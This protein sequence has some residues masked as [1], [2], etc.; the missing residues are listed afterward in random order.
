MNIKEKRVI[1]GKNNSFT[2]IIFF[3]IFLTSI[4]SNVE[5]QK[6]YYFSS[7][8]GNDFN[9]SIQ[10]QNPATPLK[11]LNRLSSLF[12]ESILPGDSILFKRGDTF[13]GSLVV[14]KSGADYAPIVISA[15]GTGPK[16]VISGFSTIS[17][18]VSLGSNIY[19]AT[20]PGYKE[21]V[22]CVVINGEVQPIGRYPKAS[23]SNG[24][25]LSYESHV[26]DGQITDYQLSDLPNWT[27]GE[28]VFRK[29]AWVIDRTNITSH[30]GNKISFIPVGIY[31]L[32]D[33]SGY[34]LQNHPS[35]LTQNG[36]WCYDNRSKKMRIYYSTPPPEVKVSTAD[37]LLVISSQNF[38]KVTD[39]SFEGA[40]TKAISANI[41]ESMT[42]D[43]CTIDF[44]GM[45]AAHLTGLKGD[46]QFIN[47]TIS[48]SLNNGIVIDGQF[49]SD[50]SCTIRNNIITNT[51][52]FA[53]MGSSGEGGY[54]GISVATKDG[55]VIE[56]NTIKNTGYIPLK[57]SGNNILIKNNIIDNY[58]LVKQDGGGI[59]TYNGGYPVK[60]FSNRVIKGNI[61][62]NGIG[63]GYG[64][65]GGKPGANGIYMDNSS[66]HV[67]II[68]NTVFNMSGMGNHNNSPFLITMTGNT[69][70]NVARGCNIVRYVMDGE[71]DYHGNENVINMNFRK[72][73]FFA[74][75]LEQT[76]FRYSD[77]AINFPT[78]STIKNRISGMGV[79]DDN[80]YHLTNDQGF[81]YLCRNDNL[82]PW[83]LPPPFSFENWKSLTGFEENGKLIPSIKNIKDSVRFEYNPTQVNKTI[84]LDAKY[85]TVDSKIYTGSITLQPYCSVIL[86]KYN[87]NL[88]PLIRSQSFKIPLELMV[89]DTIGTVVASDP[90]SDQT[91][92]YSIVSGNSDGAFTIDAL[93]GI[94]AV[95]NVA[96]LSNNFKLT[97]RVQDN[98]I[99]NLSSQATISLDLAVGIEF[100]GSNTTI[101]VYPN[102]VSDELIIEA[103]GNSE[104]QSFQILNSLG[105][106][107]FEGSLSEKTVVKTTG[108]YPGFYVLKIKNGRLIIFKKIIK[109]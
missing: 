45:Y 109:V 86:M 108:F 57:F 103:E 76:A 18:W 25:Y 92:I 23:A 10:A 27:G 82:S 40:N 41:V 44:S 14:S 98:G 49:Y 17:A 32:N 94:L 11:S 2:F 36:D 96:A 6:K 61:I 26:G 73:I 88:A 80:Y 38:I 12:S 31:K 64:I 8:E 52:L 3:V 84:V 30:T 15:Y 53:G 47:S 105:H 89:G 68:D 7:T 37:Q 65:V 78:A 81:S 19:E 34:F 70:F 71:E 63:N 106:L 24:G 33:N 100:I 28:I 51:A 101:R 77:K 39:I 87:E 107:V 79:F 1:S 104:L 69:F 90:D 83:I 4:S 21:A 20:V 72:N 67:E 74:V 22:N 93:T 55:A 58:L 60:M 48:N 35:A 75:S 42:I 13:F 9:T 95:S 59:Y 85:Y 43:N 54:V 97:V 56:Y 62:S 50:R 91:I 66:N 29:N 102:P 5:G 46:F 99:G 16:P